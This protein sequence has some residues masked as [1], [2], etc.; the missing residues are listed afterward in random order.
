MKGRGYRTE[1][2]DGKH[3]RNGTYDLRSRAFGHGW[4]GRVGATLALL[5]VTCA[6]LAQPDTFSPG[7]GGGGGS[8]T[9]LTPWTIDINAAAF[10][11][12]NVG[13]VTTTSG[14]RF[15]GNAAGVSNAAPRGVVYPEQ[16]G[17]VGDGV[18]DDTTAFGA[19]MN[20]VMQQTYAKGNYK[21]VCP[22]QYFI[23]G[24]LPAITNGFTLEG[25]HSW[26]M[27]PTYNA[28]QPWPTNSTITFGTTNGFYQAPTANAIVGLVVKDLTLVGPGH[29]GVNTNSFA[30]SVSVTSA[31]G[32]DQNIQVSECNI[33]NF[34]HGVIWSNT[35]A[36]TVEKCWFD[37]CNFVFEQYGTSGQSINNTLD[38]VNAASCTVDVIV[39]DGQLT[40]IGCGL[41][42]AG[43]FGT[44]KSGSDIVTYD[45][46]S[47]RL[48]GSR[49]LAIGCAFESTSPYMLDLRGAGSG[50]C[51]FIDCNITPPSGKVGILLSNNIVKLQENYIT[52]DGAGN[53]IVSQDTSP[54]IFPD[55]RS[56][57][58]CSNW[59]SGVVYN[60]PQHV[61]NGMFI[62]SYFGA[63]TAVVPAASRAVL[64]SVGDGQA[65][66]DFPVINNPQYSFYANA[67]QIG[68]GP[69]NY[70]FTLSEEIGGVINT[71]GLVLRDNNDGTGLRF[72]FGTN[73]PQMTV[74]INGSLY[75]RSNLVAKGVGN[76]AAQFYDGWSE[77]N[78]TTGA[79][80]YMTNGCLTMTNPTAANQPSIVACQGVITIYNG[81][82]T[83]NFSN[84]LATGWGNINGTFTNGGPA[85]FTN[86]V[87]VLLGGQ[88][89]GLGG[90]LTNSSGQFID[91]LTSTN[92]QRALTFGGTV[93]IASEVLTNNLD[94]I[95]NQCVAGAG[96]MTVDMTKLEQ[97]V[98]TNTTVA[99]Q[100]SNVPTANE[101]STVVT[102]TNSAAS[103]NTW[104]LTFTGFSVMTNGYPCSGILVTN[105]DAKHQVA[106][107]TITCRATGLTNAA[108]MHIFNP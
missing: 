94:V 6:A 59:T 15:N 72:G 31:V 30:L 17:A 107:I 4:L 78:L 40:L 55:I 32:S 52:G 51:K 54:Q 104:A 46:V 16:F 21:L 13:R 34:G 85:I 81:P 91:G 53:H 47:L 37:S 43:N 89:N 80:S 77:S 48:G 35:A 12:T 61:R 3:G 87:T 92:D 25:L 28:G 9:N 44:F 73:W 42:G 36:S 63:T 23:G 96:T 68:V 49:V 90:R 1:T 105:L 70:G 7:A 24:T 71:N 50:D 26:T 65:T 97:T 74:D 41:S 93:N 66:F 19:A 5:A 45:P 67:S 106:K 60:V 57:V 14:G 29:T 82:A 101:R 10:G 58:V 18:T 83:S 98:I 8:A 2:A 62:D 103:G 20:Y 69:A 108:F 33:I 88:F 38:R 27:I 86:N 39:P 75:V 76:F 84:I 22:N 100:L 95:T 102:I 11:L 56:Q 99:L 64:T 79:W